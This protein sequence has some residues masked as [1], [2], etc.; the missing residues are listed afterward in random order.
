MR[1]AY[2]NTGLDN[3]FVYTTDVVVLET[4]AM[5]VK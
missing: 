4:I 2:S 1:Q 5:K 3:A